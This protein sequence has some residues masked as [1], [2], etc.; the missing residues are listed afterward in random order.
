MAC[1][2]QHRENQMGSEKD[3]STHEQPRSGRIGDDEVKLEIK[4][5]SRQPGLQL[6][7]KVCLVVVEKLQDS[8]DVALLER[9]NPLGQKYLHRLNLCNAILQRDSVFPC[10]VLLQNVQDFVGLIDTMS[11]TAPTMTD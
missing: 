6:K 5:P 10:F 4:H 7:R 2:H 3:G 8:S 9:V 1:A 11:D